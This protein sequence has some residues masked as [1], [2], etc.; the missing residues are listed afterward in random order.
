MVMTVFTGLILT[1]VLNIAISY[2]TLI[3]PLPQEYE[4]MYDDLLNKGKPFGVLWDIFQLALVP[5]ICE[6]FFF[7][8]SLQT[9]LNHYV[10]NWGTIVITALIFTLYHFNIWY[11]PFYFIL[12]LFFGWLFLRKNN[13]MFP[14]T[15]H[16]INNAYG[17]ILYHYFEKGPL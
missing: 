9:S 11:A 6:E 2:W 4:E 3:F 1:H 17:V 8:A 10:K 12:G 13:L 7:R 14:I 16:F 15:A 5:A